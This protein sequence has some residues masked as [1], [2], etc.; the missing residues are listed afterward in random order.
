MGLAV[1]VDGSPMPE[2][3]ARAFWQRFS[4]FME[5]NKGDLAGFAAQE[6]FASVHPGVENG[7]PVLYAS[8]TEGQRPYA[9]VREGTGDPGRA[10][11][12]GGRHE[13]GKRGSG[14]PRKSNKSGRNRRA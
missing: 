10:G 4:D 14:P 5:T 12:S 8:K 1:Y 3:D 9:P 13:P 11:G 2:A 7:R 6:G